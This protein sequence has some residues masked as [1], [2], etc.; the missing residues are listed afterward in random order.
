MNPLF[1]LDHRGGVPA[2]QVPTAYRIWAGISGLG[3]AVGPL[4][5]GG[6]VSEQSTGRPVLDHTS[7]IGVIRRGE[8]SV[9]WHE[10]SDPNARA[11]TSS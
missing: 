6:S 9:S 11:S 4:C 1:A 8:L 5:F 3:L 7:P 2:H 10:S